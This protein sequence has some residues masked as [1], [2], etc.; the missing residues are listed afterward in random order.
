MRDFI[1]LLAMLAGIVIAT[2]AWA[3][4]QADIKAVEEILKIE[5]EALEIRDRASTRAKVAVAKSSLGKKCRQAKYDHENARRS[6]KKTK[7]YREYLGSEKLD[8]RKMPRDLDKMR[9]WISESERRHKAYEKKAAS[10]KLLGKMRSQLSD[11]CFRMEEKVFLIFLD[12][13]IDQAVEAKL[14]HLSRELRKIRRGY[15]SA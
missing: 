15:V 12:D 8:E 6:L 7:E 14:K 11:Q 2:P 3:D 1:I 13:E 5:K 9:E 10:V 4:E